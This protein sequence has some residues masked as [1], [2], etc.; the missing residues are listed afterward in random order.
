MEGWL[1]SCNEQIRRTMCKGR[2]HKLIQFNAGTKS[3]Y[4]VITSNGKESENT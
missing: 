4:P 2:S 3:Q 1:W